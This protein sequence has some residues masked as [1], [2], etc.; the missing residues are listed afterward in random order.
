M[1]CR[2]ISFASVKDAKVEI[3]RMNHSPKYNKENLGSKSRPYKCPI[4]G[5]YHLTTMSK[6]ETRRVK[7]QRKEKRRRLDIIKKIRKSG[8]LSKIFEL[9][10]H[11]MTLILN[12]KKWIL[13]CE[14][15]GEIYSVKSQ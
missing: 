10:E 1:S 8:D 4:C 5:N 15:F 11:W 7:K 2:K 14:I 12:S 13:E 6:A 9:Q 3:H